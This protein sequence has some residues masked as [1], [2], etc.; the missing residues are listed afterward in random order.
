MNTTLRATAVD[1]FFHNIVGVA[2]LAELVLMFSNVICRF[3]FQFSIRGSEELGELA[4]M[5]IAFIGGAIAYPRGE[6]VAVEILYKILPESW[7]QPLRAE[8]AWVVVITAAVGAVLAIQIVFITTIKNQTGILNINKGWYSLPMI[9][10]FLLIAYYGLR[11]LATYPRKMTLITGAASLAVFLSGLMTKPLWESALDGNPGLFLTLVLFLAILFIGVP[12]GFVLAACGVFFLYVSGGASVTAVALN[13]QNSLMNFILLA[14]PFFVMAGYVMTEGGLS[15]R[16]IHFV[17]SLVGRVRGGLYHVIIVVT[18][19]V[20]GL[21]G[22]KVADVTAVGTTMNETLR[23]EGYDMGET[24]AVLAAAAVMGETVPPCI[25]MIVLGSIS[26]LSIGTLFVAGLIPAVV[27]AIVLMILIAIRARIKGMPISSP[28]PLKEIMQRA[29]IALPALFAPVLLVGGIVLGIGTPT[30]ISSS[31]VIYSILLGLVV[32][33][34]ISLKGIWKLVVDSSSVAGMV[35]FIV[36]TASA[37]S[38][39]LTIAQVPHEIAQAVISLA[40]KS[41]T[42]FMLLSIAVLIVMGA[43]LEGLPAILIFAPLLLPIAPQFGIHPLQL[44]IVLVLSM[45]VGN[46]LPPIGVGAYV[47]VSVSKTTLDA[48]MSR[49]M[50]YLIALIIGIVFIGLVP[51]FSLVLPR[52]FHM[53]N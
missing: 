18:Y 43:M 21:S 31:A 36:S 8:A 6:H 32:Y 30:E 24:A 44:G 37:F 1:R 2:L 23:K 25:N 27:M 3:F 47:C 49:F 48:M 29:A 35:L 33:R 12:I 7:H 51:W 40:G 50:P 4:V 22:S 5:V 17:V 13:M 46:F 26:T 19:I 10:G 28:V 15:K 41:G 39:S 20:S 16:L 45:G 9:V 42:G 38:W 11:R 34:E 52:A 53:I 14:I